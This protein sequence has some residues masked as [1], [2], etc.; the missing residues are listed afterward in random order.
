MMNRAMNYWRRPWG[1]GGRRRRS[2]LTVGTA[3]VENPDGS[4]AGPNGMHGAEGDATKDPRT[5]HT[6]S[7]LASADGAAGA[8]GARS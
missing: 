1:G 4:A 6:G 2:S 3:G 5:P 8:D 7:D